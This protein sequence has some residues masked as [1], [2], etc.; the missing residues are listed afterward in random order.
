MI[1]SI[2]KNEFV[3]KYF[4]LLFMWIEFLWELYL[5]YR[6]YHV[7]LITKEVPKKLKGVLSQDT[8]KKAKDYSVAKLEFSF[9]KDIFGIVFSTLI[10]YYDV[11]AIFWDYSLQINSSEAGEVSTSCIWILILSV[12]TTIIDL[13]FTI[14]YT[15]VLEEKFGFNKQTVGFFVWDK[16]K[17]F[18][19]SQ[20][21]TLMISSIVIVIIKNGGDYFFV[22]LWAAV[23]TISLILMTV[24]PAVIAP[25]FDKYTPLP[26]GELRTQIEDL[27]TQLKFPLTELYVVEGSKRSAHSNAYFYGFF[28]HKRIVLYDTLLKKEDGTGCDNDEILGILSHELGHWSFNHVLKNLVVIQVNLFLLFAVFSTMFKSPKIYQVAGFYKSQPV[29]IGLY[30][31]LMYIMT[32][33][34]ALLSFLSTCMSRRFEFQ[35]DDF[36][37]QLKRGAPLQSA[38]IQLNKDNLSFPVY[39]NWYSAYNHSH[40]PILE[41]LAVI[42]ENMKKAK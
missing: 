36:A 6:Q 17:A 29:L 40:P 8:F 42:E 22:W 13:P 9:I 23:C 21:L 4:I 27:A 28:K 24:Y 5:S 20:C 25:M 2:I 10:I 32:P 16:I 38:L 7:V 18:I 39:D 1:D 30:V 26:E 14:Y 31:V 19:V 34:N 41:R 15:F 12:L 11:L 3:I 33:Y 35:A 37:V